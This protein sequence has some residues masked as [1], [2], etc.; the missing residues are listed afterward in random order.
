[1]TKWFC[2]EVLSAVKIIEV[3]YNYLSNAT[4]WLYIYLKLLN[5]FT[6]NGKRET[7]LRMSEAMKKPITGGYV[8]VR[9]RI[10]ASK[11]AEAQQAMVSYGAITADF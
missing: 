6:E 4:N 11:L 9:F 7:V 8:E 3:K 10:P 5:L 1:M 2:P